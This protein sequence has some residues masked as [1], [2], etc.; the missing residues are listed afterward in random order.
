MYLVHYFTVSL[1][2]TLFSFSF[3][4]FFVLH[5]C[6]YRIINMNILINVLLSSQLL[7]IKMMFIST[8]EK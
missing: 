3:P 8:H 4:R 7:S 1:C 6:N 2:N 5:K